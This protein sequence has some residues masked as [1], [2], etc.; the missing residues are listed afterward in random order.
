V[1]LAELEFFHSRRIAPT[2]R[3][4]LG[5]S[6]LPV[7]PAPGFGG[8]LLGGVVAA[9]VREID[10]DL[11]PEFTRLI[12][13]LDEGRRIP[14]PR[15]RHRFQ[16]DRIGLLRSR[17]RLVGSDAELHFDFEED[18]SSAEQRVLAAVYAAGAFEPE[19]RH[20]VMLAIRRGMRWAGPVGPS[21]VAHLS[22]S[23]TGHMLP[24]M[25][26]E[27][28]VRWALGILGFDT[29]PAGSASGNGNGNGN[30]IGRRRSAPDEREVQQRFR[31]RLRSAHPDHGGQIDEAAQRIADLREARRILLAG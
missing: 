11:R 20:P 14:Q 10:P 23:G 25:A 21:L 5:D 24:A 7:D 13:Q 8:I 30:G 18:R 2:R 1:I 19:I 4:A 31:D 15:L 3:V 22:G 28:P 12:E 6:N 26:F 16:K 17:L 29:D 27:D 9:N